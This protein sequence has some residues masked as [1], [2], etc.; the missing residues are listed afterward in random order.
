MVCTIDRLALLELVF[1]HGFHLLQVSTSS[2]T[3]T[4]KLY[5]C[6]DFQAANQAHDV[7]GGMAFKVQAA[8]TIAQLVPSATVFISQ[9]SNPGVLE[10]CIYATG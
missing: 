7:T 5:P 9:A 1:C 8:R 6:I 4:L 2:C 10:V 3:N